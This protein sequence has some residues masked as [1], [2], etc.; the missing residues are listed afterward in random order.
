MDFSADFLIQSFFMGLFDFLKPKKN[1]D[2]LMDKKSRQQKI[3]LLYFASEQVS[4]QADNLRAVGRKEEA[5]KVVPEYLQKVYQEFKNEPHNPRFLSLFTSVAL[6]LDALEAG[7]KTLESV[8]EGNNHLLLDL[9]LVYTD[10]GRIYHML[11]NDQERELWCYEMAT[12][13]KAP[14]GCKVPATRQ[15]KAKAH[16]FA[17]TRITAMS[18]TWEFYMKKRGAA[19]DEIAR[20]REEHSTDEQRADS[21]KKRAKELVPEV[22]WDDQAQITKFMQSV[23]EF[24]E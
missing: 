20:A 6:K 5:E 11:P 3:I 16:C 24:E 9:T 4:K 14:S 10:L 23:N 12:A 21:H 18:F 19:A 1:P 2:A 15:Q 13:A 22:D 8:I 7:K 17:F